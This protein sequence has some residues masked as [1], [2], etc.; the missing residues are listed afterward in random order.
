MKIDQEHRL[1]SKKTT[2][3]VTAMKISTLIV[4]VTRT[5][6]WGIL[7]HFIRK[8]LNMKRHNSSMHQM[9]SRSTSIC[10][11]HPPTSTHLY[12]LST[13][14]IDSV[15]S[16]RLLIFSC[17][18]NLIKTRPSTPS[19]GR[20]WMILVLFTSPS[21]RTFSYKNETTSSSRPAK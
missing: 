19:W 5:F 15:C 16:T 2:N 10:N 17:W 9:P 11:F 8:V 3:P 12:R 20:I 1:R 14:S 21:S 13:P 7:Y 18:P 4:L 6:R